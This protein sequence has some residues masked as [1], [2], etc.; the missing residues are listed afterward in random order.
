MQKRSP[1]GCI[2]DHFVYSQNSN[3]ETTKND[4][5]DDISDFDFESIFEAGGSRDHQ[6]AFLGSK[7]DS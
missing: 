5:D 7:N 3:M 1:R 4:V 2:E 6:K